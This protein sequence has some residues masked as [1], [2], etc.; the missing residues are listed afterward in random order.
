MP[1]PLLLMGSS[2]PHLALS[3]A[4]ACVPLAPLASP[5]AP[6]ASPARVP[7]ARPAG[8]A[9]APGGLPRLAADPPPDS[10]LPAR[11][12]ASGKR[13]PAQPCWIPC[14]S[15]PP[16]GPVCTLAPQLYPAGVQCKTILPGSS[17]HLV[18]LRLQDVPRANA[19]HYE[20][21]PNVPSLARTS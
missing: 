8:S 16:S 7:L 1:R 17:S 21:G 12:A 4:P 13:L 2:H 19:S 9:C 10:S 5:P 18:V 11:C 15:Y 6:L 3:R 20:Q 14:P